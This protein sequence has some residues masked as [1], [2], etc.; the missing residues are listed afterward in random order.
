MNVYNYYWYQYHILNNNNY[1]LVIIITI[2]ISNDC[3]CIR[4]YRL[5]KICKSQ[6]SA[7][8]YV[9][10]EIGICF[11]LEFKWLKLGLTNQKEEICIQCC[12]NTPI[13]SYKILN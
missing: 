10:L 1:Y 7:S 8:I 5:R 3:D 4:V 9:A 2:I 6:Q 12:P 11:N 13:F